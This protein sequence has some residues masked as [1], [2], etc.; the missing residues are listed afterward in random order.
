MKCLEQHEWIERPASWLS[1]CV[2]GKDSFPLLLGILG[3]VLLLVSGCQSE[4]VEL[5]SAPTIAPT[6]ST[7]LPT[8]TLAPGVPTPPLPTPP[9]TPTAAADAQQ[10]ATTFS[11]TDDPAQPTPEIAERLDLGNEALNYGNYE[12]AISQFSKALRQEPELEPQVQAETLYK[13]GI[14]YLAEEAM[15]EAAT[16]FNQL[17]GLA[18]EETPAPTH[19]HLAQTS[20]ALGDFETAIEQ[21]LAYLDI[22]PD[23]AAYVYP[24]IAEAYLA[25]DDYQAAMEAYESALAGHAHRLKEYDTR[26]I[27]A[28]NYVADG[29]YEAA[30]RHYDAIIDFAQTET[31][32]GQMTY[33]AG[34]AELQAENADAAY[35]RFLTGVSEYPDVYESYLGL[36]ELVKAEVT[37]DDYQRGLVDYYAAAYAP[38]ISAFEAHI[39]ADPEGYEA[40]AHLYLAWSYEALEDPDAAFNEL[41]RY[42]E[43]EP[44]MALIEQAQMRS[45]TGEL[46]TAIDLYGEFLE[47]Y[48]EDEQAS[49]AA[50][51]IASLFEETGDIE[52]AIERFPSFAEAYPDHEDAPEAL[53][54]A[55]WLAQMNE[56]Q[57]TA[58]SLWQQ[59]A[60]MYQENQFGTAAL[61]RLLRAE[62]G[63]DNALALELRELALDGM[64]THYS[65]LRARD[66]AADVE[67][68]D[69]SV[70]FALPTSGTASSD[71]EEAETWL[72][73]L[74]EGDVEEY[75]QDMLATLGSELREDPRLVIGEKLWELRLFAE[76]KLE[77]EELRD[78]KSDSLLDSYRLAL[79]FR[80]LGLYRSSIIAASKVLELTG[81]SVLEAP[82]F[83]GRLAYP[84][85]FADQILPLSQ[86]Y[87]YDPRLQFSLVR[88]ESLFESFARSGAA[89]QGLSQVIP[90]TGAYIAQELIWPDFEN[91]DLYKPYVGLAFGAY[92]LAEQLDA[93]DGDVHAALAAY[94]AGPGNAA[95][96]HELAGSDIDEFIDV[97]DFWET[98]TY[99]Q[100]IYAGFDI[101]RTLYE[102]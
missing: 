93:F 17:L 19:F 52:S 44:A 5:E 85:Y 15:V 74:L 65:A 88:Q 62:E 31:T 45:R 41:D 23:M 66:I 33:L 83:I 22:H 36:V 40:D 87:G 70:P 29:D 98:R 42:A 82:P 9:I 1:A 4:A 72:L 14:A 71:Q 32:R 86:E 26:L 3:I 58:Q 7:L 21:Y 37:V 6:A 77:L 75:D 78:S 60:T 56:D 25:L 12:A 47:T 18:D 53:Y 95:R 73:E 35:E 91:E 50:W 80:D 57:E 46:E 34:M 20:F 54:H 90:D 67:P 64:G 28:N 10:S 61:V 55:G 49:L 89:A 68:F 79:F 102:P 97:V 99:I 63:L 2:K 13:L 51:Q 84:V 27:L 76:A 69:S 59:G 39:A 92:Y 81:Q 38:G 48:P 94:N 16:M 24:F 30:I 8:P 100:R 96:W 11:V 101:Y 43:Y